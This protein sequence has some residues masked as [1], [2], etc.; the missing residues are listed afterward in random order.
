M[1]SDFVI[2]G[3]LL[4]KYTG[5]IANITIPDGVTSI[6]TEAFSECKILKSVIIPSSVTS[7]DEKA[8][9]QSTL[10]S[11]TIP[12]SVMSIGASAFC[13]CKRL[14]DVTIPNSVT[15]IG[16]YAFGWTGLTSITIPNSVTS[17]DRDVFCGC[18]KLKHITIPDSVKSIGASA[19]SS[20][21]SLKDVTIPDSV[22]SIGENAFSWSGL[23]NITIP[24]NAT[25]IGRNVFCDCKKLKH[26]TIPDS[27]TSIGENAFYG[28]GLTS[29]TI[30]GSVTSIGKKA[31][32]SCKNL[33]NVTISDSVTNIGQEAFCDS[34]LTS[35]T[36]PGSVTKIGTRAFARC[37]S[38]IS[39]T[40]MD[41]VPSIGLSVFTE[42]HKLQSVTIPDS[43]TNIGKNAFW[44]C[45]SL[46]YITIPESVTSIGE[47]AF[48]HCDKLV[49]RVVQDSYADKNLK[50][51]KVHV[52]SRNAM[53]SLYQE[54]CIKKDN[55]DSANDLKNAYE[56]FG[57]ISSYKDSGK[58][59]QQCK[60]HYALHE[61]IRI[62]QVVEYL[63]SECKD[64]TAIISAC[65]SIK[66]A[67]QTAENEAREKYLVQK[68]ELVEKINSLNKQ[69]EDT[70]SEYNEIA[71]KLFAGKKKQ[72]LLDQ[73]AD[74]N[75]KISSVQEELKSLE[76]AQE[77]ALKEINIKTGAYV[78]PVRPFFEAC[79]SQGI[80]LLEGDEFSIKK[81][82]RIMV[83][84]FQGMG[85]SEAIIG[86]YLKNVNTLFEMGRDEQNEKDKLPVIGQI[87]DEDM[88]AFN[89]NNRY[90][91]CSPH[92]KTMNILQDKINE[93]DLQISKMREG[94]EAM[95]ELSFMMY[96][97]YNT[98][99]KRDWA[100]AGGIA[101]GLAG[102]AAGVA[103]AMDAMADNARIE[104]Q[105]A[106]NRA[107]A[108]E[109]SMSMY[110]MSIDS[111]VN[112]LGLERERNEMKAQLNTAS[113]KIVLTNHDKQELFSNLKC[114]CSPAYIE[115]KA[116]SIVII[117]GAQNQY[118]AGASN[119]QLA[120][121][122]VLIAKIYCDDNTLINSIPIVLP[123]NGIKCGASANLIGVSQMHMNGSHRNYRVEIEPVN[124]WLTEI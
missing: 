117:V 15:S 55:L 21:E 20:C 105:N 5:T 19:F 22:T 57:K 18:K 120:I 3:T 30:P 121:D 63:K 24:S 86:R 38:L 45:N 13:S 112:R 50:C 43:V 107:A 54:A 87:E 80:R 106:A 26:I 79:N 9:Y 88:P 4:K 104:Q 7:I 96:T 14:K 108:K 16:Q 118:N 66:K 28:S 78:F 65:D 82:Q 27:I 23:T 103:A 89:F 110:Q 119:S 36:I 52:L 75:K 11:I 97:S 123:L 111:H 49:A 73:I 31:F 6:G 68:D 34:G 93:L 98:T 1:M 72:A 47:K 46:K 109:R 77:K 102:P 81:A 100:V 35:I 116:E 84:Q 32:D 60:Q 94:E 67:K 2:D 44:G 91:K 95:K 59:R 33:H 64:N 122:G 25:S 115:R 56:I 70:Q 39:A 92:S 69:L 51:E 76:K 99:P 53:E 10:T 58:L 124:L 113:N 83:D 42:C 41:G 48:I 37:E 62:L 74:I 101:S 12:D 29:I 114:V 85:I 90:R 8:F 40:I 17:I 61:D 71:K